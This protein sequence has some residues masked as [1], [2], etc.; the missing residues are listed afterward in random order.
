MSVKG[1]RQLKELLIRYSD[2]DGSSKGIREWMRLNLIK[3]AEQNPDLTITTEKK[4]CVHPFLRG[5]YMNTN[6]KTIC[7]KNI[8]PEEINMYALDLRNQ[9]G[10]KVLSN[11]T[12]RALVTAYSIVMQTSSNGYKKAVVTKVPSIQGEW[13]ERLDLIDLNFTIEHKY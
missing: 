4:R 6:T 13:N 2:Y 12:N 1:V 11:Y 9:I 3:F 8:E 5:I 7:V 10:R